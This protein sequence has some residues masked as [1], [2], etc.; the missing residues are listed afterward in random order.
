M[1]YSVITFNFR[2]ALGS[3]GRTSWSSYPEQ[4]DFQMVINY[5]C[6][7]FPE[8]DKMILSGYSYGAM[9]A[10]KMDPPIKNTFFLIISP[11]LPPLTYF[12]GLSLRSKPINPQNKGLVI[13]GG[14]DLLASLFSWR[15]YCKFWA[16]LNNP[17]GL[18]TVKID[19]AD[20]FWT[21]RKDLQ[22]LVFNIINWINRIQA[23][24]AN[25]LN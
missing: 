5:V 14:R 1:N 17:N 22:I 7:N 8:V 25:I 23:N 21:E 3:K 16:K 24:D 18:I 10:F 12:L 13:Y 11:L 6:T 2:G 20:H 9:I 15:N 19:N 4:Q